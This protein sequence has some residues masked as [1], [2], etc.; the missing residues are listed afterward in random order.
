MTEPAELC[1]GR[2]V[3]LRAVDI[4]GWHVPRQRVTI[5]EVLADRVLVRFEDN[6]ST[7]STGSCPIDELEPPGSTWEPEEAAE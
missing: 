1:A 2:R 4:A 5:V 7:G 3:W 6:G